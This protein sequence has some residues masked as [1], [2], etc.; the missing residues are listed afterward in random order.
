MVIGVTA[1]EAR[2]ALNTLTTDP[3]VSWTGRLEPN[4][5]SLALQT[6]DVFL[7]PLVDGLSTR[8]ASVLAALE[9]GVPTV[10]TT[11]HL[12]DPLFANGP[13]L[14]TNYEPG[15]FSAGAMRLCEEAAGDRQQRS[16]LTRNFYQ[17]HFSWDS[18]AKAIIAR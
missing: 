8:R 3:Q 16:H 12:F 10:S 4:E 14:I 1:E 18:I 11:G 2:D 5:V 15:A 9:H 17:S 6:L 7:A 13:L